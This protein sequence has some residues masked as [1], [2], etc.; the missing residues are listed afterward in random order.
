MPSL[1]KPILSNANYS[2]SCKGNLLPKYTTGREEN[3]VAGGS[4]PSGVPSP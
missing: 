1:S 4:L 2:H 3:I